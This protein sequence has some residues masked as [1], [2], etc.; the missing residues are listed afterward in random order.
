[1]RSTTYNNKE[2]QREDSVR[3]DARGWLAVKPAAR[4]LAIVIFL[5][6]LNAL[7]QTTA[8]DPRKDG[9]DG[10]AQR[11]STPAAPAS[12]SAPPVVQPPARSSEIVNADSNLFETLSRLVRIAPALPLV[13]VLVVVGGV[14]A[15][16]YFARE[17][18]AKRALRDVPTRPLVAKPSA[19]RA[20]KS[21]GQSKRSKHEQRAARTAAAQS[22]VQK[23]TGRVRSE[24]E[25]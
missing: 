14:V 20:K 2:S 17:A 24:P 9:T 22:V 23:R 11:A 18:A 13:I 3:S 5:A 6:G 10:S 1:V 25:Q 19:K 8:A 15:S 21:R 4:W 12:P 16:A 7:A